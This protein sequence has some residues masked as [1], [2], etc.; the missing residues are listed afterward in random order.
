MVYDRRLMR[1][2]LALGLALLVLASEAPGIFIESPVCAAV[3]GKATVARKAT[4]PGSAKSCCGSPSC[5]MHGKGCATREACPMAGTGASSHKLCAPACGREG[6]RVMPG[7]PDPGTL[8]PAAAPATLLS[9]TPSA[10]PALGELPT[11]N[12]VPAD[13]P[14]RA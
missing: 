1:S 6:V 3:D 10:L 2:I 5:P 8:D 11:C 13:P 12:P 4:A 14:P 7:V 9:E